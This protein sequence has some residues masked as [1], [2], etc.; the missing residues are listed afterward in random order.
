M[1]GSLAIGGAGRVGRALGRGLH[2]LGW[3]IGAVVTRSHASARRAT[4]YIGAGQPHGGLTRQVLNCSV[5]LGATPESA[6]RAV[7]DGVARSGAEEVDGKSGGR[8]SGALGR[9]ALEAVGT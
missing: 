6:V 7:A 1:R 8:P 2:E 9:S 3:K 4:R 5:I